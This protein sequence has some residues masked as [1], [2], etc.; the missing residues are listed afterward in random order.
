MMSF[1]IILFGIFHICTS[2]YAAP[3]AANMKSF[4]SSIKNGH[5]IAGQEQVVFSKNDG[6]GVIT[7]QSFV[8]GYDERTIVKYYIDGDTTP[9]IEFQLFIAHGIGFTAAEANKDVPWGT[10]RIGHNAQNGGL[11]NTYRIPFQKSINITITNA[12]TCVFWYIVRGVLNYPVIIG[13][14]LL[15]ANTRLRLYKQENVVLQPYDFITMANITGTGGLLFQTTFVANSADFNYLEACVR[16]KVDGEANYQFLSSGTEDYFLS[17]FYF[18]AGIYQDNDAGLTYK[19]DPGKISAYKFFEEDPLLFTKDFVLVWRNMERTTGSADSCPDK[20]L[21]NPSTKEGQLQDDI[22][23]PQVA[24]VTV[25][26]YA[27]IYEYTL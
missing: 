16:M 5:I 12:K 1:L 18:D 22:T 3:V 4:S 23:A 17:A 19:A 14:L 11:Y 20:F 13:D 10:K 25:T 9:T 2:R 24:P 27:W 15:P 26:T 8:A 6:P 7:E 21:F